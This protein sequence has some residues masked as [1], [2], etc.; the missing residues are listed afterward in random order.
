MSKNEYGDSSVQKSQNGAVTAD[1]ANIPGLVPPKVSCNV[2][3][4]NM[5]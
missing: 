2:T 5:K 3:Y 1:K 4:V